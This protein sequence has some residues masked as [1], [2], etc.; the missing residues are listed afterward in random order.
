MPVEYE[1]RVT[2]HPTYGHIFG[3]AEYNGPCNCCGASWGDKEVFER[4]GFNY[5]KGIKIFDDK[6]G[7]EWDNGRQYVTHVQT[8][9]GTLTVGIRYA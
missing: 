5:N 4:E 1:R 6:Y 9:Q 8:K 2:V 3:G 7:E